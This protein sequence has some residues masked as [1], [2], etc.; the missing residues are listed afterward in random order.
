MDLS[1]GNSYRPR[2][3][4]KVSSKTASPGVLRACFDAHIPEFEPII[5]SAA[6]MREIPARVTEIFLP[7]SWDLLY[8]HTTTLI[9]VGSTA[10]RWFQA[11]ANTAILLPPFSHFWIDTRPNRGKG[12]HSWMNIEAL[13][14]SPVLRLSQI[15]EGFPYVCDPK[16]VL[17]NAILSLVDVVVEL[18]SRSFWALQLLGHRILD[19]LTQ[20]E[21]LRDGSLMLTGRKP[22]RVDPLVARILA[23]LSANLTGKL[24]L[25]DIARHL[26]T[27]PSTISHHYRAATGETALTTHRRMRI[28]EV[29]RLLTGG[30]PLAAIAA[31]TGY[32]DIP[33]LS[34]EFKKQEGM[35]PKSLI[36]K[37]LLQRMDSQVAPPP[38][39]R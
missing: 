33:H 14:P 11:G 25:T 17:G 34:R 1:E 6:E 27:S 36:E 32:C 7:A 39:A 3:M 10:A 21:P 30:Q 15:K 20:A 16:G 19:L 5:R 23:Y 35:T 31:Q 13:D 8:F 29:K 9:R 12:H 22:L 37:F 28:L 26:H 38:T 2:V 4:K 18:Q 24:T